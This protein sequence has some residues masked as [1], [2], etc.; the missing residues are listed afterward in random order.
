MSLVSK[1][2]HSILNLFYLLIPIIISYLLFIL[3]ILFLTNLDLN[4]VFLI[5]FNFGLKS[6]LS[7]A[8]IYIGIIFSFIFF[9]ISKYTRFII[10]IGLTFL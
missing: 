1:I 10:Y 4:N 8:I 2:F 9:G 7:I 6:I 3:I 5:I